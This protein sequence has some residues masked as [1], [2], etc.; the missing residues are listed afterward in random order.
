M[1]NWDKFGIPAP[2]G[3]ALLGEVLV[4]G[5]YDHAV[6]YQLGR[7]LTESAVSIFGSPNV[8]AVIAGDEE[9]LEGFVLVDSC[10][11]HVR[12]G[13]TR[14]SEAGRARAVEHSAVLSS[15]HESR[16]ARNQVLKSLSSEGAFLA[17]R[18]E[19]AGLLGHLADAYQ[20]FPSADRSDLQVDS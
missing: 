3:S 8:E 4:S 19:F 6:Q 9:L 2:T 14:L 12:A 5:Y 1:S 16:E 18:S 13:W 7:V 10:W 20:R 17:A 15:T 11:S